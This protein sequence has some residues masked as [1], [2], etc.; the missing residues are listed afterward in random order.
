VLGAGTAGTMVVIDPKGKYVVTSLPHGGCRPYPAR[1]SRPRAG[2]GSDEGDHRPTQLTPKSQLDS[3]VSQGVR[4]HGRAYLRD[5]AQDSSE[6]GSTSQPCQ[7]I[8]PAGR[9]TLTGLGTGP[10]PYQVDL[11]V[12]VADEALEIGQERP[13]QRLLGPATAAST[14][15][16]SMSGFPYGQRRPPAATWSSSM[17][18]TLW[19]LPPRPSRS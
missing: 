3:L 15:G 19:T 18:C 12:E 2:S 4:H 5:M 14:R 11:P 10:R 8:R 13:N 7:R 1:A 9:A 17:H 16:A 6:P